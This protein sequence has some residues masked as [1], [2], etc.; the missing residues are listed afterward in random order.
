[1]QMQ[2]MRK[3]GGS[4]NQLSG[5]ISR[6]IFVRQGALSEAELLRSEPLFLRLDSI[7]M[8]AAVAVLP[9]A[10][11]R[12]AFAGPAATPGRR[13]SF[14]LFGQISFERRQRAAPCRSSAGAGPATTTPTAAVQVPDADAIWQ[15]FT[16]S[17]SGEWEGVTASFNPDGSPIPLPEYYVPQARG[18]TAKAA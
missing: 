16:D 5:Q 6:R 7:P 12:G 18:G 17:V 13:L 14:G 11:A 3:G 9:R 2:E 8:Q 1:M 15:G 10:P 4:T